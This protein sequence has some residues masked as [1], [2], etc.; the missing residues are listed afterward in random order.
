MHEFN[1][2]AF[3]FCN[4]PRIFK[5]IMNLMFFNILDDTIIVYLDKILIYSK[6]KKT[7]HKALHTVL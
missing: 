2:M 6:D 7:H 3:G 1:I 5:Y 4:A